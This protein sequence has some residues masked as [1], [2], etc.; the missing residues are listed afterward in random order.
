VKRALLLLAL[1]GAPGCDDEPPPPGAP[2]TAVVYHANGTPMIYGPPPEPEVPPPPPPRP[3]MPVEPIGAAPEP[4]EAERI[5]PPA[6]ED[7]HSW[8]EQTGDRNIH[9]VYSRDR[10]KHLMTW[11][12]AERPL[13]SAFLGESPRYAPG[14]V[15]HLM[16]LAC[17]PD[18]Q[19]VVRRRAVKAMADLSVP[20]AFWKHLELL[21]GGKDLASTGRGYSP[22][23]RRY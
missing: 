3:A 12:T 13:W 19:G 6:S 14:T 20:D 18:E 22:Y 21:P 5:L 7:P 16:Q 11:N 8:A 9:E 23:G 1:L 10:I 17:D 4:I 15:L 2:P